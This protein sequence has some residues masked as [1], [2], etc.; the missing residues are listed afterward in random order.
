MY[1]AIIIEDEQPAR[2]TL[3]SYLSRYF[4]NI[5]I[6]AE[7]ESIKEAVDYLSKNS[8]DIIFLDV[9]LEDGKGIDL[10]T[11]INSADYKIIFTT[12]H[13]EYALDAF[14]HKAFGYL[15]KPLDPL[16]FKEIVGR[17]INDLKG[18][19][20]EL[21]KRKIKILVG[22]GHQW[23]ALSEI[24]RCEAKSNYTLIYTSKSESP[25]IISKTLKHMEEE[26][27]DSDRFLRI[28]HSHLV[29]KEFILNE[30]IIDNHILLKTGDRIPVSRSRK[31]NLFN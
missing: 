29:N 18:N 5:H 24:I 7:I 26:I 20:S 17:V 6:V 14:K 15:V 22:H 10:L 19:P 4:A 16:D 31:N 2:V 30:I 27:L 21:S 13:E 11:K 12:A 23:I 28:H 9:Q 8:P 1:R 3:K 25:L